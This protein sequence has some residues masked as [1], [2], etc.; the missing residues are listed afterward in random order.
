M[1]HWKQELTCTPIEPQTVE[2]AKEQKHKTY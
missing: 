2:G 1:C